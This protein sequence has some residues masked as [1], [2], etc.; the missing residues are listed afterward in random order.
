MSLALEPLFPQNGLAYMAIYLSNQQQEKHQILN[1]W[2]KVQVN[3]KEFQENILMMQLGL[4]E[5]LR[6]NNGISDRG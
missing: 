1:V 6:Q 2:L 4:Q 5:Q 3:I